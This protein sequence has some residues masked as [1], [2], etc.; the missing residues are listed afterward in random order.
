MIVIL[1]SVLGVLLLL[2]LPLLLSSRNFIIPIVVVIIISV[3]I[4]TTT[5][6]S[7]PSAWQEGYPRALLTR[8]DSQPTPGAN[9][10]GQLRC[11]RP[12]CG[13]AAREA[14]L[15]FAFWLSD[16]ARNR[17]GPKR[18][19]HRWPNPSTYFISI[20]YT[21]A[22]ELANERVRTCVENVSSNLKKRNKNRKSKISMSYSTKI[23]TSSE[24]GG[25]L[26]DIY[27]RRPSIKVS[28]HIT[29]TMSYFLSIV[30]YISPKR[31]SITT[32]K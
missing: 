21:C 25:T 7:A 27:W 17:L 31:V 1:L 12:I 29:V 2:P 9:F 13:P 19:R 30:N 4:P 18:L 8:V 3:L 15:S 20:M 16:R 6:T 10:P 5:T 22:C 32:G 28:Q 26:T 14:D 24:W 23:P 11:G